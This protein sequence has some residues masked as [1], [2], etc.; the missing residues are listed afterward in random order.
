[1]CK[2]SYYVNLFLGGGTVERSINGSRYMKLLVKATAIV[3]VITFAGCAS[4]VSETDWPICVQSNPTGAKCIIDNEKGEQL[5]S[6]ETPMKLHL[7]GSRGYFESATYTIYCWKQ[8]YSPTKV[9]LSSS[10]NGWYWGN[11]LFGGLVGMF[12]VDPVTGA[13][14]KLK[15]PQVVSLVK[16]AGENLSHERE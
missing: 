8:G 12:M 5:Y 2:A 15:D 7:S 13:M 11:I 6:G 14:W 4:I 9:D 1:M 3:T 16:I 10:I